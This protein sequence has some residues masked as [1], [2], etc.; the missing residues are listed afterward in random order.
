MRL[1]N[2]LNQ[3]RM[4]KNKNE[5]GSYGGMSYKAPSSLSAKDLENNPTAIG[6][7]INEL[8]KV[9]SDCKL[10]DEEIKELKDKIEQWRNESDKL[11][12]EVSQRELENERI[13]REIPTQ[14]ATFISVSFNIF[15]VILTNFGTNKLTGKDEDYLGFF[16]MILG[17]LAIFA[18]M[19]PEYIY[20]KLKEYFNQERRQP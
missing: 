11:K 16:L 9:R 6:M 19:I 3:N 5:S 12:H 10:K 2:F 14:K 15:G 20:K 13:K 1:V 8:N 18:S 7:I 17:V 4:V